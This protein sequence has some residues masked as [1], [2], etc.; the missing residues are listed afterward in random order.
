MK[1]RIVALLAATAMLATTAACGGDDGASESGP[2]RLLLPTGA[3]ERS[4]QPVLAAF[5]QETGIK[6]EAIS[7]PQ[8]DARSRQVLDLNNRAGNIDLIL[9]D[10]VA[11]LSEVAAQLEPLDERMAADNVDISDFLPQLV[12]VFNIDDKQY[13]F[14]LGV[15]PR[16]LIYRADLFEAAGLTQPP[17][18][19]DEFLDYAR[20]LNTGGVS[21][22]V[23][24]W[25]RASSNVSIWL[26]LAFNHGL[27]SALSPDGKKAAFNDP[28]G[29]AAFK[30]MGDLYTGGLMPKD[31]IEFAHDGTLVAMQKGQAA[32]TVLPITFLRAMNDKGASPHAGQFRIAPMPTTAG[33]STARYV[34]TG[35][36]YGLSKHTK[37]ADN[38]WTLLKF[39]NDKFQRPAAD[40]DPEQL[41]RPASNTAFANPKTQEIFP[42]GQ[43]DI[44]RKALESPETRPGVVQWGEIESVLGESLQQV[45]LGK[46]TA[47]Q[48]LAD[49]E[50][51][52]NKILAG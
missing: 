40:A 37:N 36:G 13:A 39:L 33:V 23:G 12:D 25:G 30:L 47:E 48:A 45:F 46:M 22:F 41:I 16:T 21:G 43:I 27:E 29:V 6:V 49:A 2:V 28:A 52:V 3:F 17:T 32:M 15:S 7:M 9:L 4:M 10:D 50:G 20:K 14:P 18:T 8:E 44:V 51:K 31:S 38:A 19:Y 24:P 11:W 26:E 5:T 42:D 34:V 35:W 1:K